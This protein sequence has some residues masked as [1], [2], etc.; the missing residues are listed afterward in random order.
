M[1]AGAGEGSGRLLAVFLTEALDTSGR[2][3]NLLFARV[4]RM[5]GGADFDMQRFAACRI[6]LECIAAAAR[7]FDFGVGR[8]DAFFHFVILSYSGA[9]REFGGPT[10]PGII[11]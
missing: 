8:V 7:Y 1:Q 6:G 10:E 5:A 3:H 9:A 4:E 11:R 2:V